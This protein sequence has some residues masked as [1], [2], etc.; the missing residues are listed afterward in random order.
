M[1]DNTYIFLDDFCEY[2]QIQI[3]FFSELIEYRLLDIEEQNTRLCIAE[4]QLPRLERIV[5]L[6]RDL[7]INLPGIEVALNLIEELQQHKARIT[8][9]ENRLRRFE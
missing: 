9:L 1:A 6:N 5:R 2:H 7:D 8:E 4:H 3:S